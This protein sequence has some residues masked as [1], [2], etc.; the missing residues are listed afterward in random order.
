MAIILLLGSAYQIYDGIINHYHGGFKA[1]CVLIVS[2][3]YLLLAATF[4]KYFFEQSYDYSQPDLS[5][6]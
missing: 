6:N 4:S 3:W 5:M 1:A 2:V